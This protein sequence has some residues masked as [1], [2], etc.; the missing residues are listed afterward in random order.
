M[1]ASRSRA[2]QRR[3]DGSYIRVAS[4]CVR[5]RYSDDDQGPRHRRCRPRARSSMRFQ[6]RRRILTLLASQAAVAIE[7]A[8]E[9]LRANEERLR[10]SGSRSACRWR[11]RPSRQL[12]GRRG[13]GRLAPAREVGG[14]S[15]LSRAGVNTLSSPSATCR[16]RASWRRS[17]A[18]AAELVRGRTFRRR[19][20]PGVRARR[21]L[22]SITIL[23]RQ[24][25]GITARSATRF[26]ISS[27]GR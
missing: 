7:N 3:V 2:R 1:R 21:A 23:H 24:L 18:F 6:A 22:A 25:E 26:S 4:T 17:T 16:A 27:A 20:L 19:Y 11:C 14:D 8:P 9:A 10:K 5:A 15:R 12:E 13:G